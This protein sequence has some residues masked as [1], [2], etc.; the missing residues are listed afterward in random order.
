MPETPCW[1]PK[2]VS[3]TAPV[4]IAITAAAAATGTPNLA[5]GRPQ[6]GRGLLPGVRVDGGVRGAFA[7]GVPEPVFDGVHAFSPSATA[8]VARPRLTCDFTVPG[9]TRMARGDLAFGQV[10]PVPQDARLASSRRQF[11]PRGQHL[12]V[13][14]PEHG[15]LLRGLLMVRG[16]CPQP[17]HAQVAVPVPVGQ[18]HHLRVPGAEQPAHALGYVIARLHHGTPSA[19]SGVQVC[20]AP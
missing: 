3:T 8:S 13:V 18:P 5:H 1:P 20:H 12:P 2:P 14:L 6:T 7:Q 19:G 11:R 10:E 9:E 15:G 17:D 4:S 16:G